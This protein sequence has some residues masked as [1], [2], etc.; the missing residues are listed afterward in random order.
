[1]AD[2]FNHHFIREI[3]EQPEGLR[4]TLAESAPT[5]DALAHALA[6]RI[7]RVVLI[8]CGDPHFISYAAA[9]AFEQLAGLPATPVDALEFVLYAGDRLTSHTLIVAISQSGKTIQVV[10]AMRLARRAG[11]LCLAVTN[12]PGSPV[13]EDAEAVLLIRCGLSLSFPT[14][15]TT[16]ALALLYR[17]AIALGRARGH[18][19]ADRASALLHELNTL[20]AHVET[21]LNLEPRLQKL[22]GDLSDC[23]HFSFISTG[24]AYTAALL[25]EAK[26]KET[27]QTRAEAHQL[28]EF[29]HVHL[30]ALQSG[31]PLFFIAPTDRAS[32]RARELAAYALSYGAR[33]VALVTEGDQSGW[34]ALGAEVIELPTVEETSSPLV[35]VVPLQLFAYH[36]ALAK[37][38]N[39]DRP[40]RFDNAAHQRLVYSA[41]LEGWHER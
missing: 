4:Q 14:K 13:T 31:D 7:D 18:L 41:L 32:A 33:G 16:S 22:V 34:Q 30:F 26:L 10:Q 8:G 17:L 35:H 11:A 6:G 29:A 24:P 2:T 19:S 1:M 21:V 38:H 39:P 28:E 23:Q 25:G 37:G 12:S 15:T 27:S 20:P 40:A 3:Y 5:T 36:L 9:H